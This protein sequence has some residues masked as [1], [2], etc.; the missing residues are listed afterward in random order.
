MSKH[1]SLGFGKHFH[2]CTGKAAGRLS[3]FCESDFALLFLASFV[4]HLCLLYCA[5]INKEEQMEKC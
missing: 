3:H 2:L 4:L 5:I 1:C